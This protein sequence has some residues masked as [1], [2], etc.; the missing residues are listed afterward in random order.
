M[1]SK[2]GNSGNALSGGDPWWIRMLGNGKWAHHYRAQHKMKVLRRDFV[3]EMRIVRSVLLLALACFIIICLLTCFFPYSKLR[4]PSVSPPQR[5]W[6]IMFSSPV[7]LYRLANLVWVRA[8]LTSF[9]SFLRS[10]RLLGLCLARSLCWFVHMYMYA[11][12]PRFTIIISPLSVC[13]CVWSSMTV[14]DHSGDGIHDHGIT[15]WPSAQRIIP[16]RGRRA[17]AHAQGYRSRSVMRLHD[18]LSCYFPCFYT[19]WWYRWLVSAFAG[20]RFL[21]TAEIPVVH[22]DLKAA[23]VLITE[24]FKAKVADF[25]GYL[26]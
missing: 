11:F 9:D 25:G 22:G 1:A 16:I 23:N 24:N 7:A 4:H 8:K 18:L 15:W 17:S 19:C 21:H 10:Q 14:C 3:Q 2:G 12:L 5:H 26:A 20:M 6:N 13:V